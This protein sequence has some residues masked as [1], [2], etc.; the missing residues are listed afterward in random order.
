MH[1]KVIINISG[2][3][4]N[5]MFM[6]AAA[7]ALSLRL[8]AKLIL[9]SVNIHNKDGY[10]RQ[11]EL[12]RFCVTGSLQ[13]HE[14]KGRLYAAMKYRAER[15]NRSWPY[16]NIK[17]L[18]EQDFQYEP[19]LLSPDFNSIQLEGYWQDER[20]FKDFENVIR[21]D[22][23]FNISFNSDIQ[24][25]YDLIKSYGNRAVAL[26]VRRYQEVKTFVNLKLTEKEYYVRAIEEMKNRVNNPMLFCFSQVPDWVK[27]ELSDCGC[28]LIFI[29]PKSGA[30][31]S[32][33]DLHLLTAFKNFII[34][35]STF[36]WWGAWLSEEKDKF[37]VSPNNW[38]NKNCNCK[39][40][41]V[42]D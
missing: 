41:F 20:Y 36:Y 21:D 8:N 23:R 17:I 28:E 39:E 13:N 19:K 2:G 7:R 31:A 4:G 35:N 22:F 5:Q 40:W 32:H 16:I 11:Y 15:H 42:I 38:V 25:E 1:N 3:L 9:F 26:C 6:Y 14:G 24:E 30:N 10:G 33:E 34:S 27:E 37:V 18:R 12:D 29:K